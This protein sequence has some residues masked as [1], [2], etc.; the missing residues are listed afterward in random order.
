MGV[1]VFRGELLIDAKKYA[2]CVDRTHDLQINCDR[3]S[4]V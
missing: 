2:A 1:S 3:I 4:S